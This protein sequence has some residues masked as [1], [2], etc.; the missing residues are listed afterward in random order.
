MHDSNLNHDPEL[1]I[2]QALHDYQRLG[3]SENWINQ[4][5]KSIEVC[6]QLTDEWKR[7]G[8]EQLE[9]ALLTDIITQTWSGRTMRKYKNL[10][11]LHK[12]SLRDNALPIRLRMGDCT[13]C[14]TMQP[15]SICTEHF[16]EC[17][18]IH[19]PLNANA[20]RLPMSV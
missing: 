4:R 15:K 9:Y 11:G 8:I 3:Y 2:N 5:L 19:S 13:A 6:K 14:P 18:T 12:E 16:V 10:K 17:A 7:G 20:Y 1:S